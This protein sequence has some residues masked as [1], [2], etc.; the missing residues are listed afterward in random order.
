MIKFE[1]CY[2]TTS[3]IVTKLDMLKMGWISEGTNLIGAK[4]AKI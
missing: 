1:R 2:K 3:I 4:V